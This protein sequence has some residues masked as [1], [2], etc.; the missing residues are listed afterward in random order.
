[1]NFIILFAILSFICKILFRSIREFISACE[2]LG[3]GNLTKGSDETASSIN[4][5][6]THIVSGSQEQHAKCY[7]FYA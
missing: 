6:I 5:S 7:P 2:I 1:M 4:G 3:K